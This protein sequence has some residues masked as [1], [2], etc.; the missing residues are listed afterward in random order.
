MY[1]VVKQRLPELFLTYSSGT[2]AGFAMTSSVCIVLIVTSRHREE[3]EEYKR[4]LDKLR[5]TLRMQS[6]S[7]EMMRFALLKIDAIFFVGFDKVMRSD[8]ER[9]SAF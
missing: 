3:A 6:K 5:N 9:F 4:I 1:K 7:F 8:L 2:S